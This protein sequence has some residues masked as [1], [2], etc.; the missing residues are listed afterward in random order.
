MADSKYLCNEDLQIITRSNSSNAKSEIA[1]KE[2]NKKYVKTIYNIKYI[3]FVRSFVKMT[4]LKEKRT[5]I[6][7]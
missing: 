4:I 3:L 5:R 6:I 7:Y 1:G 2:K